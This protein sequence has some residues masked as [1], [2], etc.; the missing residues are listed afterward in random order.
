MLA[1]KKDWERKRTFEENAV[2][3]HIHALFDYVQIFDMFCPIH[4]GMY[5]LFLFKKKKLF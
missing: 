3:I 4:G 1:V 5:V 2:G